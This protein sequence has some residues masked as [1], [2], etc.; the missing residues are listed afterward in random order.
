LSKGILEAIDMESYRVEVQ[1]SLSIDLK[2]DDSEI[3]PVPTSG[4]GHVREPELDYLSNIVKA[5]NDLFGSIEWKDGDKIRKVITEEI[6]QKVKEDKAYQ[7]AIKHSDKQNARIEHD[8]ALLRVI[9][10]MLVIILSS[11]SS[12][13]I[14]RH[15]KNGFRIRYLQ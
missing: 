7:N 6:P 4:G 10:A 13:V 11:L 15:L 8:K 5:F 2:D 3:Y 9:T 12:L 14:I 1:A